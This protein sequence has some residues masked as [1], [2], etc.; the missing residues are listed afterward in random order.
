LFTIHHHSTVFKQP[1]LV[2]PFHHCSAKVARMA[3]TMGT[4][5]AGF[6]GYSAKRDQGD[7][8][9]VQRSGILELCRDARSRQKRHQIQ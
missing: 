5:F 4:L 6:S 1:R 9:Q 3:N 7:E 8:A 2:E